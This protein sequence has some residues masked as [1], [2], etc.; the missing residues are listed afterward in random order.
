MAIKN[1]HLKYKKRIVFLTATRA[2]YGKIKSIIQLI[3]NNK[4][5]V[6]KVFVTGM[7]F[8]CL[9]KYEISNKKR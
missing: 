6:T 7:Q 9:W 8:G 4:K 1:K 3:Q 5:F 2:D